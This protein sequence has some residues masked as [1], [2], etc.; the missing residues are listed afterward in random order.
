MARKIRYRQQR[1][2]ELRIIIV[3]VLF[4]AVLFSGLLAVDLNKSYMLYG[5]PRLELLQIELFDTDIYHVNVLNSKFTVNIKYIKRDI[6]NIKE[7][8]KN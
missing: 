7:F 2:Y 3:F 1:I 4:V 6:N 5:E 8:L